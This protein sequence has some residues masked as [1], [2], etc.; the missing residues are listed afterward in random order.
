[1]LRKFRIKINEKEYMAN[2]ADPYIL[3]KIISIW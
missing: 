3:K 2:W 1:M